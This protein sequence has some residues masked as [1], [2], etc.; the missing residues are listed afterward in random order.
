MPYVSQRIPI[1]ELGG[2]YSAL[3]TAL[4]QIRFKEW[5]R[6]SFPFSNGR[7]NISRG[8]L[9]YGLKGNLNLTSQQREQALNAIPDILA[10]LN[11]SYV[12]KRGESRG[13]QVVVEL[14]GE[15]DGTPTTLQI[16][17]FPGRVLTDA[18]K[19]LEIHRG[20][21]L[22]DSFVREGIIT[23]TKAQSID[24]YAVR[25]GI[26]RRAH[27][28]AVR[29]A[30]LA[31]E[32]GFSAEERGSLEIELPYTLT[33]LVPQ[34]LTKEKLPDVM[35]GDLHD[36]TSI[37]VDEWLHEK[38]G[39]QYSFNVMVKGN[40]LAITGSDS[41]STCRFEKFRNLI[42]VASLYD[43][44]MEIEVLRK[45]SFGDRIERIFP[46]GGLGHSLAVGTKYVAT[47]AGH[48][49]VYAAGGFI[50]A[51]AFVPGVTYRYADKHI[52][53]KREER[54]AE[55]KEIAEFLQEHRVASNR[56]RPNSCFLQI[57]EKG[58][59]RKA[60]EKEPTS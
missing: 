47:G 46:K 5:K 32:R 33:C 12:D 11:S 20:G 59:L 43:P 42:S 51:I 17:Y 49:I 3:N 35:K 44:Q 57:D 34:Q 14:S 22:T 58:I 27:E 30:T 39:D 48:A 38:K 29:K 50:T 52:K 6:A 31:I 36:S 16:A 23:A 7:I 19:R 26:D 4:E 13:S 40:E 24:S 1:S 18:Q 53:S 55:I 15:V 60:R 56:T 25:K 45:E 9:G 2:L 41:E 54:K 28:E 37:T 21:Y 8:F 10:S